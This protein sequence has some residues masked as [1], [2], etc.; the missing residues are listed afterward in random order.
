V[1]LFFMSLYT[2]VLFVFWVFVNIA[3]WAINGIHVV[4]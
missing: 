1:G 3:R 4:N 2:S